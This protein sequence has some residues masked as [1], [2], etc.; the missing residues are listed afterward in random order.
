MFKQGLDEAFCETWEK[1]KV[2]MRKCQNQEFENIT[3]LNIFH[4]GLKYD[5]K[6]LLDPAVGGTM[7]VVDV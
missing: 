1:F 2:M 3:Q 4:N 6:M 5:T 7:M